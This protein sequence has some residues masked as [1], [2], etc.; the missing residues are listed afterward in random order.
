VSFGLVSAQS[1]LCGRDYTP[2]ELWGGLAAGIALT[3][4]A[5]RFGP[6]A[7]QA[8]ALAVVLTLAALTLLGWAAP[9]ASALGLAAGVLLASEARSLGR[10]SL[11]LAG[12]AAGALG[13]G[14]FAASS[15]GTAL[16]APCLTLVLASALRLRPLAPSQPSHA[17]P[18]RLPWPALRLATLWVL[19]AGAL[20]FVTSGWPEA[21]AL[22][23]APLLAGLALAR[24]L[25][26]RLSAARWLAFAAELLGWAALWLTATGVADS[27]RGQ[28]A[29]TSLW[30]LL[31]A[32]GLLAAPAW[33][34]QT[35]DEASGETG[36]GTGDGPRPAATQL[37]LASALGCALLG[38]SPLGT[39]IF[40]D[41]LA[42][43]SDAQ[44]AALGW[45]QGQVGSEEFRSAVTEGRI[46]AR[47]WSQR[48]FWPSTSCVLE[49][50]R[51]QRRL[52]LLSQA[53]QVRSALPDRRG[54]EAHPEAPA[55]VAAALAAWGADGLESALL[56]QEGLGD[57]VLASVLSRRQAPPAIF[58]SDPGVLSLHAHAAR[59]FAFRV[60]Q[61]E[62]FRDRLRVAPPSARPSAGLV[63]YALAP[64]A[65]PTGDFVAPLSVLPSAWLRDVSQRPLWAFAVGEGLVITSRL[66]SLAELEAGWKR[67]P[68]LAE[69]LAEV[70]LRR[71]LELLSC[72]AATPN[73]FQALAAEH[74]NPT[75]DLHASEVLRVGARTLAASGPDLG[76]GPKAAAAA[77]A[78]A[79]L[80]ARRKSPAALPFARAA[81]ATLRSS[82]T[83]RTLGDVLHLEAARTNRP[84]SEDPVPLWTEALELDPRD[85]GARLALGWH[86]YD[87]KDFPAARR[88]LL[89]GIGRD[90]QRERELQY[91]LGL[92]ALGLQE[93]SAARLHF[94][95]AR[96]FRNA[97]D[98]AALARSMA[99]SQRKQRP[100]PTPTP[101]G[102]PGPRDPQGPEP[103]PSPTATLPQARN[104]IRAAELF[105]RQAQAQSGDAQLGALLNAADTLTRAAS[106]RAQLTPKEQLKLARLL[107]KVGVA[108]ESRRGVALQAAALARVEAEILEPLASKAPRRAI[109]RAKALARGGRGDQ[110]LSELEALIAGP[111]ARL[112]AA[113]VAL[114]ELHLRAERYD[115]GV[116]AYHQA[117]AVSPNTS[118]TAKIYQA[119][120][121]AYVLGGRVDRAKS[122]LEAAARH[123][124]DHPKIM[125][126]L[127]EI[128]VQ[129]GLTGDA[130]RT[131]KAFLDSAPEKHPDRAKA[132]A[133]LDGL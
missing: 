77:A 125:L 40:N 120:A 52:R 61:L 84:P 4:L 13:A 103:T 133:A 62:G 1:V 129:L 112:P 116:Q 60:G 108:L 69:A 87:R 73:G 55:V 10:T 24:L 20:R 59:P 8:A 31:F 94:Q 121:G 81:V 114:G 90:A 68:G 54:A 7:P 5:G 71:P 111:G 109:D 126:A 74:P 18:G 76:S 72:L 115:A 2:L 91:L 51:D 80:L 95:A 25:G 63:A 29:P 122:V 21:T 110:A 36:D 58:E 123:Y 43:A 42:R 96:G 26:P 48:T 41:A 118:G 16:L 39:W 22:A 35:R 6:R 124:P 89:P 102:D 15:S 93:A 104:R 127:A 49:A 67:D 33:A 47:V 28:G 100:T 44:R 128:Y 23:A 86:H 32:S 117:L 82:T 92:S 107:R 131:L 37:L 3:P 130:K 45:G 57:G 14:H 65:L 27:V 113:H 9:A 85:V 12:A 11:V 75:Q 98:L 66:P 64:P 88:L 19:S 83:L 78:L 79:E 30:L 99:Q 38:A 132:Q 70:G 34:S 46:A 50:K 97:D 17:T 56:V 106:G 105:L 119:L 53:G 101:G